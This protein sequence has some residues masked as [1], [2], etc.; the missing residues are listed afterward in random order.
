[1]VRDSCH[2][3]AHLSGAIPRPGDRNGHRLPSANTEAMNDHLS[4]I[5]TQVALNAHAVLLVDA[6]G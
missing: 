3:P 4:E 6:A 5:R 2:D 1:M